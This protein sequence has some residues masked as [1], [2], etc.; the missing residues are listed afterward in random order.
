VAFSILCLSLS[1]I[2]TDAIGATAANAA[3][4]GIILLLVTA[5]AGVVVVVRVSAVL[6]FLIVIFLCT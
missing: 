3:H 2:T 5:G 6:A 4:E 1:C